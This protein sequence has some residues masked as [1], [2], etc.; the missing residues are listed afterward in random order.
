M[1]RIDSGDGLTP[2]IAGFRETAMRRRR[3]SRR[4]AAVSE[5][6]GPGAEFAGYRI[7][8]LVARGGMGMVYRATDSA[9]ERTV[10]LKVIARRLIG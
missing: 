8:E 9:L 1:A 3:G 2:G 4:A 5:T 6:S 10:A 7:E